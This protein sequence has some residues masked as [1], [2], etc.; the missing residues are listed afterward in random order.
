MNGHLSV[1]RSAKALQYRTP[2]LSFV[3]TVAALFM[4]NLLA[5]G[6]TLD[7][8]G[9][10]VVAPLGVPLVDVVMRYL[11]YIGRFFFGDMAGIQLVCILA[12]AVH[13]M[14]AVV[15]AHICLACGATP[16]TLVLYTSLTFIGGVTQL[17]PLLQARRD[18]LMDV[19]SPPH[20]RDGRR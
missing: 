20:R 5:Y 10:D 2:W 11:F 15:A 12:W 13:C 19:E 9:D 8:D 1:K 17:F 6:T 18:I 3:P 16:S 4:L 7:A 14:E